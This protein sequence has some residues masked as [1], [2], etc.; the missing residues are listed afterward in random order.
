MLLNDSSDMQAVLRDLD[1]CRELERQSRLMD[2]KHN[3]ASAHKLCNRHLEQ[4]QTICG[5][6]NEI[7]LRSVFSAEGSN[8]FI[9]LGAQGSSKVAF[10]QL[11]I[12][13]TRKRKVFPSKPGGQ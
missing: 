7:Q 2:S 8:P 4:Q 12:I 6:S 10:Q 13:D 5:S 3:M 11:M 1:T 9:Y